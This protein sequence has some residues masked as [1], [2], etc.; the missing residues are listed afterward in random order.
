MF[1]YSSSDSD[2]NSSRKNVHISRDIKSEINYSDMY[3]T[4][5]HVVYSDNVEVNYISDTISMN[6]SNSNNIDSIPEASIE[7]FD[8]EDKFCLDNSNNANDELSKTD[9]CIYLDYDS[10][11]SHISNN[12]EISLNSCDSNVND[13]GASV[14]DS[15]HDKSEYTS[16]NTSTNSSKDDKIINTTSSNAGDDNNLDINENSN[17]ISPNGNKLLNT[18]NQI[19]I[20]KSK[21]ICDDSK[22]EDNVTMKKKVAAKI[23]KNLEKSKEKSRL[24][25]SVY[26]DMLNLD[27][28][29]E[30]SC[31]NLL[32]HSADHDIKL[33]NQLLA[34]HKSI[35]ISNQSCCKI[36]QHEQSSLINRRS[37]ITTR[38]FLSGKYVQFII[39]NSFTSTLRYIT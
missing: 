16:T 11:D 36:N 32:N 38:S 13:N 17:E 25:F 10:D 2:S 8:S 37:M 33:D 23:N 4:H 14:I 27:A 19:N 9:N 29:I 20:N 30:N 22:I 18:C 39:S 5:S 24:D 21:D 1:F 34:S 3:S 12:N 6:N 35:L 31:H 7:L 28:E 15:E 26:V